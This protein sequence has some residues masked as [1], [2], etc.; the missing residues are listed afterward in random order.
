MLSSSRVW[1]KIWSWEKPFHKI[2]ALTYD[3]WG[4]FT[5]LNILNAQTRNWNYALQQQ[6]DLFQPGVWRLKTAVEC[7]HQ[8]MP[9]WPG[10]K[11]FPQSLCT[12]RLCVVVDALI[13]SFW[14]N[15]SRLCGRGNTKN[16][17]SKQQVWCYPDKTSWHQLIYY[18]VTVAEQQ[19]T[20]CRLLDMLLRSRHLFH[21]ASVKASNYYRVSAAFLPV[22][23]FH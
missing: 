17:N 9:K 18:L 2:S 14:G 1:Y 6:R 5:F 19:P 7:A 22:C 20:V 8:Q 23:I 12:Q 16:A 4:S 21:F 3:M 13:F 11:N 15:A 10:F